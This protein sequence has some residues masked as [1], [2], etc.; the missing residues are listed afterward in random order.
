MPLNFDLSL[1]VLQGLPINTFVPS[2]CIGIAQ[3]INGGSFSI[4]SRAAPPHA[5]A[6]CRR[7]QRAA[8]VSLLPADLL[9]LLFLETT[10]P[11]QA[12]AV[13]HAVRVRVLPPPL[14]HQE[15]AHHA[16]ESAAPRLQRHA[17]AAA[18]DLR[19]ARRPRARAAPPL[20]PGRWRPA[21]A[22]P[23]MTAD[24]GLNRGRLRHPR[25]PRCSRC[26]R[27]RLPTP[28]PRRAA[29]VSEARHWTRTTK[30]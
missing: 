23:A 29:R 22:R 5:P 8:G 6:H 12:R 9:L 30:G 10:F 21:A 28:S 26:P 7:H 20:R 25:R 14:P 15:L 4:C 18:Q 24:H 2:R 17:Q 3:M 27:A 16:Q 11:R 19:A 1:N 13:R